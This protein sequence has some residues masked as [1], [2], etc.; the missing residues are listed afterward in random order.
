ML[1]RESREWTRIRERRFSQMFRISAVVKTAVS[2]LHIRV[3]SRD[4]RGRPD[5]VSF[6]QKAR[7]ENIDPGL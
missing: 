2:L 5:L 4:S 1:A 7:I 6:Q 3:D